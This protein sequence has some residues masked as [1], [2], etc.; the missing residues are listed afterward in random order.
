LLYRAGGACSRREPAD[1]ASAPAARALDTARDAAR[2]RSEGRSPG[3]DES[4]KLKLAVEGGDASAVSGLPFVAVVS[5][6]AQADLIWSSD[7]K[8]EHVVGGVVAENV[9]ARSIKGV[10]RNGRR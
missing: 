6:K 3:R 10:A 9:D 4:L 1:A 7:G 8:V 2:G 5:D